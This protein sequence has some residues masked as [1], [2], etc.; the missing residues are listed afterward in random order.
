[1]HFAYK[2]CHFQSFRVWTTSN[3]HQLNVSVQWLLLL[4]YKFY[5]DDGHKSI[6]IVCGFSFFRSLIS[7]ERIATMNFAFYVAGGANLGCPIYKPTRKAKLFSIQ[8]CMWCQCIGV[9]TLH[10]DTCDLKWP[11]MK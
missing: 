7:G 3:R 10:M 11:E 6:S 4:M 9:D 8:K 1:M 2:V 5:V